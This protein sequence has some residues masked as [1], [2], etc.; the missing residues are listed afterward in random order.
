MQRVTSSHTYAGRPFI[1]TRVLF[2][3]PAPPGSSV[4]AWPIACADSDLPV[5]GAGL[6]RLAVSPSCLLENST[7]GPRAAL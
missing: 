2:P 5:S 3:L 6:R 1:A 7:C 4:S